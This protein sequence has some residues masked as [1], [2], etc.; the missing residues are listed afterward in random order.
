[1]LV[2]GPSVT[3]WQSSNR[4]VSAA[5][6]EPDRTAM[7]STAGSSVGDRSACGRWLGR[8]TQRRSRCWSTAAREYGE[9]APLPTVPQVDGHAEDHRLHVA[10]QPEL[11]CLHCI[12][13]SRVSAST[14]L[15]AHVRYDRPRAL[16]Q[17]LA[18]LKSP[19]QR[20][21]CGRCSR[22]IMAAMVNVR[23]LGDVEADVDGRPIEL[24]PAPQERSP[25]RSGTRKPMQRPRSGSGTTKA[26]RTWTSSTTAARAAVAN[27]TTTRQWTRAFS[28]THGA[29]AG[30]APRALARHS[31]TE[32]R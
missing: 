27:A 25:T 13:V 20:A 14:A 15:R 28:G 18:N 16:Y 3:L 24:G 1:M 12:H 17:P 8:R 32:L 30:P 6:A 2:D 11:H 21:G 26:A 7:S 4:L 31:P 29:G 22:G 9:H 19:G 23:L 10:Q 5:F